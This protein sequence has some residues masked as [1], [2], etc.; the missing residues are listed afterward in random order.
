[1]RARP[2]GPE[3]RRQRALAVIPARLGSTRLPRKMLLAETGEALVVHTARAVAASE[4]CEHTVVATDAP[5]VADAVRAAGFQALLTRDD[6]PSG[7]DRVQEA[8]EQV[9][10]T[11]DVVLNV[12][13]DEPEIEPDDLRGLVAAFGDGAVELATL[14]G[15]LHTAAEADATSVVKVVCDARG[16]ALYF[17]RARIPNDAHARTGAGAGCSGGLTALRRHIGVYAFRPAALARFC[18]LP[19]GHLERI[20]N[21]EQLRWLESGG[22]MRVVAATHVPLGIDTRKDYDAFIERSRTGSHE[23]RRTDS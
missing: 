23:Q 19:V 13:G 12:Q 8:L 5:E 15:P 7:T 3:A 6:H 17:S 2:D 4:A 18:A 9:G 16:D 14:A 21:L 20:E 11:W 1:M 22:R 10:G